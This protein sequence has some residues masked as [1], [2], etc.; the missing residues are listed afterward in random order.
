MGTTSTTAS[1]TS[2]GTTFTGSSAYSSDFQN[3]I[4]RAVAIASLPITSL[5]NHQTDLTNQ[6]TEMQT[7]D[8][9]FSA[10]QS[11]VQGISDA[12]SG[13][14]FQST[15]SDPT[16]VAATTAD[17]AAEGVYSILVS[18]IGSYATSLSGQSWNATA[19]ASNPTTYTLEVG[20]RGYALTAASNSAA[21]VA[22]AINSQYGSMV[23]AT[24]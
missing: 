4:N 16:V 8:T 5:T 11:A 15:V 20:N 23:Q 12:M 9:K 19:G 3:V 22:A 1:S 21:D 14:S 10:L 24:T 7:L 17:G 13:S 6:Q 2:S 18:N